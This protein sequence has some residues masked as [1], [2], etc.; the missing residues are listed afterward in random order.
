MSASILV[1]Y[2][3]RYGSTEGV[4]QVVAETLRQRGLEVDIQPMRKVRSLE[5]YR[6]ILL[7]A[8][9]YMGRWHKDAHHFLSE[10]RKALAER[11]VTIF[12]LGPL[13]DDDEEWQGSRAQLDK[14]LAEFAWLTPVA[15]EVFGGR[16]D[17]E[18]LHFSDRVIA[19]LPASPLHGMPASDVRDWPAIRAWAGDLAAK[20]EPALT[21]KEAYK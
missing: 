1:A 8:P 15:L 4:A 18:K 7:G 16:F 6:V 13:H 11:L 2:A 9:I 12:A 20:L 21:R 19:S 17:P 3:T 5:G 10:H 14:E